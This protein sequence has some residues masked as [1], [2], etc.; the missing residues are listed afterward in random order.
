M[1]T[2]P[3]WTQTRRPIVRVDDDE[4]SGP[5]EV[6]CYHCGRAIAPQMCDTDAS[7]YI[8]IHDAVHHPDDYRSGE[9][10]PTIN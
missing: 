2:A 3:S 4:D 7:Y 1:H 5:V 8:Y 9:P 6:Y 10:K